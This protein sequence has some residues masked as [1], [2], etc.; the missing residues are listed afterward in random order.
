M[1]PELEELIRTYDAA[2]EADDR[3]AARLAAYF[4]SRLA[5][6]LSTRPGLSRDTLLSIVRLAHRRWLR[7]QRKPPTLP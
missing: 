2:C 6:A 1:N 7:A 3:D 4:E 5:S